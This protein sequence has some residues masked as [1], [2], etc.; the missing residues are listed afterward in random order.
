[1]KINA[2]SWL[3]FFLLIFTC[4]IVSGGV[5]EDLQSLDR[6]M[7]A[8][9]TSDDAAYFEREA[10]LRARATKLFEQ[11][12]V[13][14]KSVKQ[15]FAGASELQPGLVKGFV[16]RLRF[17]VIQESRHDLKPFLDNWTGAQRDGSQSVR[18][19]KIAIIYGNEVNL[20]GGTWNNAPDGRRF[21]VSSE[22]ADL[23]LSPAEYQKYFKTAVLAD[24]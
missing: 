23:V 18:G 14:E 13:S 2:K 17:A 3:L 9:A 22:Q 16:D 11:I 8:L 21:W 4:S 6:E 24:D 19:R 12:L 5:I 7:T 1:M 15:F 10:A 20:L